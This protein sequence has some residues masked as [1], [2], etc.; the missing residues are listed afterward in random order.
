MKQAGAQWPLHFTAVHDDARSH[1]LCI[2]WAPLVL[3]QHRA[4]SEEILAAFT[5]AASSCGTLLAPVE[6]RAYGTCRRYIRLC[7]RI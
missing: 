1:L 4:S 7:F 6:R 5:A 3:K 2:V